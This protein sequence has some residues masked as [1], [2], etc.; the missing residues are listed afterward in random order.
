MY[1]QVLLSSR[2]G[3]TPHAGGLQAVR[4]QGMLTSDPC[5]QSCLLSGAYRESMLICHFI[6]RAL[7]GS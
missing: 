4:I 5:R 7:A 2:L 1:A 6:P 3:E